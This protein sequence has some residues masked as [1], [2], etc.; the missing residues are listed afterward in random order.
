MAA[1][2]VRK[3]RNDGRGQGCPIAVAATVS[4]MMGFILFAVSSAAPADAG[5]DGLTFEL[6]SFADK[7]NPPLPPPSTFPVQLVLDDDNAEGV[8]GLSGG[9]AR[10]FLWFNRFSNPGPFVLEEIWVLFPSSADV[11]AD[12]NIDLVVYLD[13]DGD[14][15]NGAQLLATFS[16]TIQAVTGDDFSVYPLSSPVN[17]SDPGD[18]LIGVI[19]RYFTM[20]T[21]PPTLPVALDRPVGQDRSYFALWT[22]DVPPIP[23]L[24]TAD[25]V[26]VFDGLVSGNCMIRGFGTDLLQQATPIPTLSMW[27]LV[28]LIGLVGGAGV[29]LLRLSHG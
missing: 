17:I 11:P 26:D 1:M 12:G 14:P 23:D 19:N 2:I 25:T 10:Q 4:L 15:A 7:A 22:G 8:F 16:E 5:D 3:P 27:G 29:F 24:A 6:K 13:P 9:E 18:V 20:G 28:L 21:P